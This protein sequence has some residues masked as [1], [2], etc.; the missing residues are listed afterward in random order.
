ML[1]VVGVFVGIGGATAQR[2]AEWRYRRGAA[3]I[4]FATRGMLVL[5]PLAWV[6]PEYPERILAVWSLWPLLSGCGLAYGV[7]LLQPENRRDV[8]PR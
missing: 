3:A 2:L 7:H 5:A 4:A 6:L 8:E 1:V